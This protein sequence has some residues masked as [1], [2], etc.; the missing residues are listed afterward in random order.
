[1]RNKGFA[2]TMIALIV[3]GAFSVGQ[4][5]EVTRLK[6]SNF[7][8]VNYKWSV[9]SQQFCDEIKKQTNGRVEITHYPG[10]TLTSAPK[11]FN[12]VVQGISDLGLTTI[13]YNKG[14]F[15][16]AEAQDIPQGFP[17]GWVGSH[18][19]SDTYAKFRPKEWNDVHVLSLFACGPWMFHS[20]KKPL[21]TL[22]DMR[23]MKMRTA[24]RQA[25]T[26]KALGGIPVPLEQADVYE[27]LRRGVLDGVVNPAQILDGWKFGE[28]IKYSTA[29][30]KVIGNSG[31]FYLVMN[32]QKWE[33]L[34][35]DIKAIFDKVSLEFHEKY[36]I[37]S[38]EMDI[39]GVAFLKKHGGQVI[40]LSDAEA[41][42]WGEATA[43]VVKAYRKDLLSIGYKQAEVDSY[44]AYIKERIAFWSQKEKEMKIP[45]LE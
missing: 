42:R 30:R 14:R 6:F 37:V 22:E 28:L 9:V 17:S 5:A 39:D 29:A 19:V 35:G 7:F 41:K 23:G 33:K 16:F 32:K 11:M 1:M 38:N 26:L 44:L 24:G 12:G 40:Y 3:L 4:A 2:V 27:A 43:P 15:P 45:T 31:V 8:P 10:G 34:P 36:A 13:I 21:R 18:V 20:L 25:E